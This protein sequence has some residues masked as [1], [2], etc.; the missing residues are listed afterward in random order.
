[1]AARSSDHARAA[2]AP[3]AVAPV[4]GCVE[5]TRLPAYV[6]LA[7]LISWGWLVPVALTGGEVATGVG[8]PTHVPSL[9][10]PM[11]AALL[12]SAGTGGGA[13]VSDLWYRMGL[14]RVPLRCWVVGLSPLLLVLAVAT[15]GVSPRRLAHRAV[16]RGR[17]PRV[18]L[19][20]QR[21]QHPARRAVA[22]RL[23][24]P[25][26]ERDRRGL[27]RRRLDGARHLGATVLVVLELVRTR[28][29]RFVGPPARST[30]RRHRRTSHLKRRPL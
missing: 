14:V 13:A 1:M 26:R 16:E 24:L 3:R 29:D 22:R 17:R 6:A 27:P 10:G 4:T 12:V 19:R 25:V 7:F 20:P 15:A 28:S 5:P 18:A 8:W 11:A 2:S 9:L 30:A 23:Q 21:R